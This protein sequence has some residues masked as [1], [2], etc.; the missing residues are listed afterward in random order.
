MVAATRTKLV[1]ASEWYFKPKGVTLV[2]KRFDA[3]LRD[4]QSDGVQFHDVTHISPVFSQSLDIVLT[5]C[6]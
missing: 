4:L 6:L 2:K 1:F 5:S 3:G